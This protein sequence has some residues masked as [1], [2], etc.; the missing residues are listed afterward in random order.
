MKKL[1]FIILS[2]MITGAAYSQDLNTAFRLGVQA[3]SDSFL[4]FIVKSGNFELGLKAKLE[5]Y[6]PGDELLFAGGHLAWLLNNKD[7][8]SSFAVGADFRSG[9]GSGITEDIDLFLRLGY[10]YH[11]SRHLMLTGIFY[12]FSLSTLEH[13]NLD[14]WSSIATVLSAAVAVSVFF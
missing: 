6:D 14:D 1:T 4:G 9:F 10:N 8:V 5:L 13:E 7:G 2:L 12:P 11:F 3:G